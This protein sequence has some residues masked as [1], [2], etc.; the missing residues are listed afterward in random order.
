MSIREK[1]LRRRRYKQLVRELSEF[2]HREL[3]ELG[4]ARA[5]IGGVARYAAYAEPVEWAA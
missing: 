3:T 1:I 4:I 5:D 2:S